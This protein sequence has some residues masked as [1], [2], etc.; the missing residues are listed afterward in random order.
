MDKID[1]NTWNAKG[2]IRLI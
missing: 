1:L 2:H